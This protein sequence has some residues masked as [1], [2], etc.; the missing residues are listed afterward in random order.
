MCKESG[1]CIDAWQNFWHGGKAPALHL[2]ES[3]SIQAHQ[4]S[5]TLQPSL[6]LNRA[7]QRF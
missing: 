3:V 4:V 6:L 2:L 1:H 7:K 5:A